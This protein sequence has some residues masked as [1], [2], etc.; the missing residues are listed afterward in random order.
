MLSP[1]DYGGHPAAPGDSA[2]S[3]VLAEHA[4]DDALV[5]PRALAQPVDRAEVVGRGEGWITAEYAMLPRATRTRTARE[6]AQLGGRTQEIQRL[7][8][9]ALRSVCDMRALGERQILIDCDVLQA[10]GGTRTASISGAYL[11]LHD[12]LTRV[13]QAG[14]LTEVGAVLER[15]GLHATLYVVGG[16][17]MSITLDSRRITRDVDAVFRTEADGLRAAAREVATRHGLDPAWLNDT[18]TS[19]LVGMVTDD[20]EGEFDVPGLS[21]G[22]ASP[23]H[24]LAMKMLAGRDRDLDDLLRE[25]GDGIFIGRIWYTYPINGL[26]AGDFTCTVVG[27]SYL[28]KDGKLAEPLKPNTVRINDSIHNILGNILGISRDR[29]GTLVWAADEITYA[30]EIAAANVHVYEIASY[31]EEL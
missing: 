23:E 5:L 20:G 17:A 31:M 26:M 13:V 15:D 6:R 30:P 3:R 12:C 19:M 1:T 4:L 21:A 2:A 24:L 7:I 8:G 18:V 22:V 25:V 11:A 28:I 10:D 9:R 29:A 14:L 27:D 16:A